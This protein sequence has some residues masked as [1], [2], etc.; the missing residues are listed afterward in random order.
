MTPFEEA[1]KITATH[2]GGFADVAGDRGGATN[3]GVTSSTYTRWR[4]Q[5]GLPPQPVTMITQEEVTAIKR[6]YWRDGHCDDLPARIAVA[7]F[8]ACFHHGPGN[9]ARLLQRAVG[10]TDDGAIGP[11]TLAAVTRI[12]AAAS[13]AAVL[14]GMLRERE[15]FCRQIVRADPTQ[16]KFL[17]GWVNRVRGLER[18]FGVVR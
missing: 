7:H 17:N 1:A 16:T 2:E 6:E 12:I 8:D 5:Q 13:D 4:R 9:A 14:A 18:H 11:K 15:L 3:Y 10:V